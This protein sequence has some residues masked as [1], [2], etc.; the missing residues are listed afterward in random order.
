[1]ERKLETKVDR[2]IQEDDP[3][4]DLY[5]RDHPVSKK[6]PQMS[7]QQRAAQFAPFAALVGYEDMIDEAGVKYREDR[8]AEEAGVD[9]EMMTLAD[10]GE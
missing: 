9:I 10:D 3:Y 1:M 5:D 6:H 4:K 8:S 7:L 2:T